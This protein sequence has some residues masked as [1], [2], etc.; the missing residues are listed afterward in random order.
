[1]SFVM[2]AS[3]PF[4]ERGLGVGVELPDRHS[5]AECHALARKLRTRFQ[6]FLT[7]D[8]PVSRP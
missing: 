1:M 6:V 2:E 7:R 5:R 4:R 3:S 8:P